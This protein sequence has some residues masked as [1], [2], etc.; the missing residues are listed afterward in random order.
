M[1][2]NY[3]TVFRNLFLGF[4]YSVN[5]WEMSL[6]NSTITVGWRVAS[7][8]NR[9]IRNYYLQGFWNN[10]DHR[11]K[12]R[13]DIRN[14]TISGL[15]CAESVRISVTAKNG[16]GESKP[17]KDMLLITQGRPPVPPPDNNAIRRDGDGLWVGLSGWKNG[18]C[19]PMIFTVDYKEDTDKLT[20]I[21][22]KKNLNFHTVKFIF[23]WL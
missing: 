6:T 21:N 2:G 12:L 10:L 18:G 13:W 14:Y 4:P 3:V 19:W 1:Y 9:A 20:W 8:G 17:S 11:L 5:L 16:V 23:G 22:G 15:Q 7:S